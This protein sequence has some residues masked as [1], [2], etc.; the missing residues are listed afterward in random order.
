M[1][2][3]LALL[4]PMAGLLV[5]CSDRQPTMPL[6]NPPAFAISDGS[7]GGTQGF[8][9]LPPL[10][11]SPTFSGT[12]NPALRPFVDICELTADPTPGCVAGPP[13]VHF[14]PSAISVDT[15]KGE[16]HVNWKT[17]E[18]SLDATK[19]YRIRVLIGSTTQG[20]ELGFR[21]VHPVLTPQEGPSDAESE[22]V[23]FFLYGNTIP[24]KFRIEKGL[25]CAPG[26]TDCG[27]GTLDANGGTVLANF[28]GVATFEGTLPG[29]VTLVVER[30]T[31]PQVDGRIALLPMD[32]PQFEGCYRVHTIPVL[33]ERMDPP[34]IVGVCFDRAASGLTPRQ[35]S[36]LQL[37]RMDPDKPEEGVEALLNVEFP[38]HC[39]DFQSISSAGSNALVNFASAGWRR[40]VRVLS[41]VLAPRPLLA[42]DKG[43]GGATGS[44]SNFVWALPSR[45][46]ILAGDGQVAPV[47][48]AVAIPPAVLVTDRHGDPVQNA[49]VSFQ[50]TQGEGTVVPAAPVTVVTG[51][52]GVA[53][54]T[55]WTLG[56]DPGVNLLEASGIGLDTVPTESG[57]LPRG[58][59]T[60]TA[61]GCVP[62]A[63][64][65]T[66]TM[67]GSFGTS[68]WQCARSYDFT[69][70]VSGGSTPA[71]L[72]VMNDATNIYLA[73]R[74]R[75][76]ST[77]K[78]N[79]L[80]FNFDNN[81]S[82]TLSAGA[83]AAET[84]DEV[85]SLDAVAGFRDAFLTLKCVNSSQSSCWA[86]DLSAGGTSEGSGAVKND[87]TY[88][89]YEVVHPLNTADNAHDFSLS[90]GSK[91]GVFLTLQT[92]S[93]ATGNTQWPGFRKYL[94]I[95][96]VP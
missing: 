42:T 65:G 24:I 26:A 27:E 86:T 13:R 10:V 75:R 78:V 66:A 33:T 69:A 31:C 91:V 46:R 3:P 2:R 95:Q 54:V 47:S 81:D 93:G 36:L 38:V 45:M 19:N 94:E 17:D 77:D 84:G 72:Y 15:D 55:S 82:W 32:I 85:L 52:D 80:Q 34:A 40:M 20:Q 59:V 6:G 88:T 63:G 92:G 51:A 5:A 89:T 11:P 96:I 62:G 50:V 35:D 49:T 64:T 53:H 30:L 90:V 87:G 16:Y 48:T 18:P 56:A 21:D 41:P 28:G 43:L 8:Y 1:K 12:F 39:E 29:Q 22:D 68:E 61:I 23:Y 67:D 76:S 71:T 73:V 9:F 58:A 79:T 25:L 44:F 83:G 37:H 70:N 57:F 60:F 4:V 14:D 7:H 74:I